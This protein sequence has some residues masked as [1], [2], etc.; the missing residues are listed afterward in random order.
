[1]N[2]QKLLLLLL[3]LI[4][5]GKFKTTFNLYIQKSVFTMFSELFLTCNKT[6]KTLLL[7]GTL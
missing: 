2:K 4:Q 5:D 7:E 1:M 3:S 6:V